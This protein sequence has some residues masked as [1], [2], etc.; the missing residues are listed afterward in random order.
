[1]SD[2]DKPVHPADL[3]R[4][5]IRGKGVGKEYGPFIF[6]PI[7]LIIYS[8]ML[9]KMNVSCVIDFVIRTT[10]YCNQCLAF[11]Y[12]FSLRVNRSPN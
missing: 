7:P 5:K 9:V 6:I 11:I 10:S 8:F 3:N 4:L 12:S 1:M 2:S